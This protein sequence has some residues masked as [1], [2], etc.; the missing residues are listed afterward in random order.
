MHRMSDAE[1][2][3][4]RREGEI[5]ERLAA[6]ATALASGSPGRGAATMLAFGLGTLPNLLLAGLLAQ[7]LRALVQS[8]W[9][10]RGAGIL[11]VGLGL[12]GLIGA[13]RIAQAIH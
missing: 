1:A 6:L 10:R 7:Q 8:T 13:W 5:D 12:Y 11:V 9:V 2:A 4:G 3:V